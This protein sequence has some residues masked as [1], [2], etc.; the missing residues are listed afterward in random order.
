MVMRLQVQSDGA[1]KP[2]NTADRLAVLAQ[3]LLATRSTADLG[4]AC[5]IVGACAVHGLDAADFRVLRVDGRSGSLR[6]IESSGTEM[7]YLA[8]SGGPVERAVRGETSVYEIARSSDAPLERSLWSEPPAALATVTLE[9]GGTL[10]GLLLVAFSGAP[11]FDAAERMFLQ[12]LGD[13]LGLS[14]ER[15]RLRG[16]LDDE[17]RRKD[18]L[19][20]ERAQEEEASSN[21]MSVVAHEIRT[22]LTAIKA[23]TEALL[24]N[25]KNDRAPRERFLGIINDE[26]DRL[27][28]LVTDILDLSKLEAG[29]RPLRLSRFKLAELVDESLQS[30]APASQGRQIEVGAEVPAD[31]VPEAD[32]DLVRRLLVNLVGNAVKFSPPSSRVR[33]KARDRGESW[34]LVVEDEGP[35]IPEDELPYVF[36][37]FYRARQTGESDVEGTGL[38]LAISRGIVELHG[39]RIWVEAVQPHG[40]RFCIELPI[41]QLASAR[42]RRIARQVWNRKDVRELFEQTIGMVAAAMQAEIVSLILVDPDRGDLFIAAS[43]GL[44]GQNL[45]GRRTTVRSGVAGTVAAYGR[46]LLV[47]NIETDRRFRR[48]NHPQYS[49]KSLLCVPLRVDGEVLGVL[50]VNN[51]MNGEAF[52]EDDLSVLSVLVERIGSAVERAG[53]HPESDRLVREAIE[54]VRSI[55]RLRR[56]SLLG[57][58]DHVRLV[59]AVARELHMT[60]SEVDVI[61]YVASIHDVGMTAL[62]HVLGHARPLG[63][64]QRR[65]MQT[66]PAVSLEILRPLEYLGSVR[67]VILSHHEC[68]DGT[69]YPRGLKGEEIPPGARVLAVTDAFDSMVRGRPY[70]AARS[71]AE[72][73]EELHRHAGTQ[74]DPAVVDALERVLARDEAVAA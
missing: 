47:N 52:D 18:Q 66:H 28:R 32:R 64:E 68:W 31:L 24:D 39:G 29:Q 71:R 19:E 61:G 20:R 54:A 59:R 50:N 11:A 38:G 41:R 33:V 48:L 46:P 43:R 67:E 12:A 30:L 70:R 60:D 9:A 10:Q 26:C 55:T 36:E 45:L 69:G 63:E 3:A 58:Q 42:A 1:P 44:E 2:A 65:E 15:D 35:G 6:V 13:A 56:D 21:L 27:T 17:R 14:L 16:D 8:D 7:P 51:K 34:V 74:F 25:L 40:S 62:P 49:T 23:Y 37:R 53:A 72:A 22:P 5:A 73:L 4:T 57:G